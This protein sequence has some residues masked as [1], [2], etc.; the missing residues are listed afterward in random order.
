MIVAGPLWAAILG[1]IEG[2]TAGA[3]IG[4]LTGALVGWGIP[5]DQTQRYETHI[6]SGKF[7]VLA[8]GSPTEIEHAESVLRYEGPELLEISGSSVN[9]P[10]S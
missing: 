5:S 2:S 1:G 3:A 9:S 6:Q 7:L 4:G 10:G 8:Q